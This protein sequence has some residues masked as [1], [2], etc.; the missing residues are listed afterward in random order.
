MKLELSMVRR[1][2]R[3]YVSP[4]LWVLMSKFILKNKNY[5][6]PFS[7]CEIQSLSFIFC[8]KTM[9]FINVLRG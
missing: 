6:G 4:R 1:D 9:I 7:S 8:I 2:A 5:S 3:S